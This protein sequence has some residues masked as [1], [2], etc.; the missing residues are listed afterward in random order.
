M[1]FEEYKRFFGND[2]NGEG[3]SARVGDYEVRTIGQDATSLTAH[4]RDVCADCVVDVFGIVQWIETFD[5]SAMQMQAKTASG[6]LLS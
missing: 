5:L 2:G 1:I 6:H 4:L 3:K